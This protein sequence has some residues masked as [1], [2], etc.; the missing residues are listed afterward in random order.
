MGEIRGIIVLITNIDR[1]Y[2]NP[3]FNDPMKRKGNIQR[4]NAVEC[5]VQTD[6]FALGCSTYIAASSSLCPNAYTPFLIV[7]LACW[8]LCIHSLFLIAKRVHIAST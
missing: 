7:V 2:D 6:Y 5:R 3:V 4:L 8:L 1:I